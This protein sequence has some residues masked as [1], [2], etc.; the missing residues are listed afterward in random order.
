MI[1]QEKM[2]KRYV[3]VIGENTIRQARMKTETTILIESEKTRIHKLSFQTL[4]L[5]RVKIS[6]FQRI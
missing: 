5:T 3:L 1:T 2:G 6:N 4:M